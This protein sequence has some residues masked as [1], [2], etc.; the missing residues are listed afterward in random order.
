MRVEKAGNGG[1]ACVRD[2]LRSGRTEAIVT[3][4]PPDRR[5]AAD[6][7]C[8]ALPQTVRLVRHVASTGKVRVLMTNLLDTERFP[9]SEFGF[10]YHFRWQIEIHHQ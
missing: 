5:D 8:E 7:E 3:L 4:A 10:F 9:A 1:F 6:Y 2:F